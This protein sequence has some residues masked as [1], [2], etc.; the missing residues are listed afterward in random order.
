[1]IFHFRLLVNFLSLALHLKNQLKLNLVI[2][3]NL[4]LATQ[5]T[6]LLSRPFLQKKIHKKNGCWKWQTNYVM[7]L[8][9]FLLIFLHRSK[10]GSKSKIKFFSLFSWTCM[11]LTAKFLS[12]F[13]MLSSIGLS[14][15]IWQQG[16]HYLLLELY[17]P[18]IMYWKFSAK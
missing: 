11:R 9:L 18:N 14:V 15:Q 2:T 12:Q 4:S 10:I 13:S 16:I 8:L 7:M 17:P 5:V 3:A 1:M 6:L